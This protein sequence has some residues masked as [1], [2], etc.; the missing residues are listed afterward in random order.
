M[1]SID[2]PVPPLSEQRAIVA[3]LDSAFAQIDLLKIKLQR[4]LA[5]C[6]AL[7]QAML[8]EVFE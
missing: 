1:R 4:T 6:D 5:E 3:R 7:K 8:R 2:L